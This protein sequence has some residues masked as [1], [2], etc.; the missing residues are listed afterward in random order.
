MKN[1]HVLRIKGRLL[2]LYEPVVMGVINVN[3]NSFYDGSRIQGESAILNAVEQMISEGAIVIDIGVQSSRPGAEEMAA[4]LEAEQI[5]GVI[6]SI[7]KSM[8]EVI[9][10]ADTY[11]KEPIHAA[12]SAGADIVNDITGGQYDES[13]Y[14]L[15]A[16]YQ[17]PY[18][19]MHMQGVPETMQETFRYDQIIPE[20]LDFFAHRLNKMHDHGLYDVIIDPG[21][22]FGKSVAHN[23]RLLN[24]LNAFELLACPILAGVSRKSMIQKVLNCDASSALNGTT[25]LHM[26]ALMRGA[27]ILRVHDV[28]EAVEVC[29]LYKALIA[30]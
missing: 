23:Y 19:C 12:L 10:S 14:A 20:L 3:D 7:K 28:R 11:R 16:E 4:E 26:A 9:L 8:P 6:G 1:K 5:A 15:C 13:V 18:I 24:H 27:K 2:S 30:S 17:A 25:A 29:T 21:F 22:G